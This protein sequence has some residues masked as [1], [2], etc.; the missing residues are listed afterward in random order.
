M[1]VD[2][3]RVVVKKYGTLQEAQTQ[4]GAEVANTG[5]FSI[6]VISFMQGQRMMLTGAIPIAWDEGL[7]GTKV[8]R[9]GTRLAQ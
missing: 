1:Q 2:E 4:A 7:T 5:G 9:E 3:S 8:S 6:P